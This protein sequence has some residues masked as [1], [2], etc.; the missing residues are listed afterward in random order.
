MEQQQTTNQI[1][2]INELMKGSLKIEENSGK[3]DDKPKQSPK[4]RKTQLRGGRRKRLVFQSSLGKRQN[5]VNNRRE[6][7]FNN[8]GQNNNSKRMDRNNN[9]QRRRGIRLLVR[10]LTKKVTNAELK[11]LFQKAGPLKRCGINYNEVGDTKGTADIEYFSENDAFK[12]QAKFNNKSVHG[13]PIRIEIKGRRKNPFSGRRR[14]FGDGMRRT[15]SF[16][17]RRN[18]FGRTPG[19]GFRRSSGFGNRNSRNGFRN[20]RNYNDNRRRNRY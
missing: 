16:G 4:R 6:R 12:A 14:R 20:R 3:V 1:E 2:L 11:E 10:N 7:N 17:R 8:G 15:D 5:S 9:K 13:V 19:N 18:G